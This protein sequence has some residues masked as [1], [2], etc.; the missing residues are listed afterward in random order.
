MSIIS[1]RSSTF[2]C[3]NYFRHK[4][5]MIVIQQIVEL[6]GE[7]LQC[8]NLF[9]KIFLCMSYCVCVNT[10]LLC[11]FCTENS[12]ELSLRSLLGNGGDRDTTRLSIK[13]GGSSQVSF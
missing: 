3:Y 7:S 13:F 6:I 5:A 1:E 2:V 10:C 9:V 4:K 11:C 12:I 8:L